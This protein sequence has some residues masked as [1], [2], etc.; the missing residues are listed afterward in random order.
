MGTISFGHWFVVIACVEIF[1]LLLRWVLRAFTQKG[2][3]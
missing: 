3:K 1:V 2:W